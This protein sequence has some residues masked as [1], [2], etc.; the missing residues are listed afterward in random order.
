MSL[1]AG[2]RQRIA[3]ARALYGNPF[4]V[5]LDEPN[6]NLDSDG[7]RALARAVMDVRARGGIV[8]LVAHGVSLLRTVDH[9]LVL[10]EGRMQAFGTTETVLPMLLPKPAAAPPQTA[11]PAGATP[12]RTRRKQQETVSAHE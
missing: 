12:R 5:V 7:E 8:V 3:L 4:L 2:Q 10:N 1:S 9:I 11:A 6:A